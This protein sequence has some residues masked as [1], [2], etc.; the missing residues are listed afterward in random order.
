MKINTQLCDHPIYTP[1]GVI[2]ETAATS[3]LLDVLIRWAWNGATGG[4][5]YGEARIG[6][7]QALQ[8]LK[9]KLVTRSGD[10]IPAVYFS[11]A[12]RDVN[13]IAGIYR[14]L[15]NSVEISHS[16]HD[17]ADYLADAM[18]FYLSDFAD[19]EKCKSVVLF[20]DEM[21]RLN[22]KQLNIFA[23]LYDRLKLLQIHL[24]TVF[25]GNDPECIELIDLTKATRF[26]HVRGR[27]FTQFHR[28]E[29]LL[30]VNDVRKCLQ[31]YDSARYPHDGPTYTE[32]FL[33][34]AVSQGFKLASLSP[35][36]WKYFCD[37]A[38]PHGFNSWGMQYFM[39]AVNCLLL[40]FLPQ[41]G[42]NAFSQEMFDAALGVS[43]IVASKV[44]CAS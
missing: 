1:N 19:K 21:Q 10:V 25:I 9:S 27:F 24:M 13:S 36:I 18:V 11:V 29:G 32:N 16:K 5:V 12:Q 40:D 26:A 37:F 22:V 28:F 44:R 41:H 34:L 8:Q 20:V 6:K 43:G 3:H 39:A 14:L 2:L 30:S 33:P 17:R 4:L 15:C 7:T 38:K 42:V 23:E 31:Q 35:D